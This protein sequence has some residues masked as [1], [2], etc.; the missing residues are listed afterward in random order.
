MSTLYDGII[1]DDN[2]GPVNCRVL[3]ITITSLMPRELTHEQ[4][5][6]W[7]HGWEALGVHLPLRPEGFPYQGAEQHMRTT[8][9]TNTDTQCE[10]TGSYP[11]P[12]FKRVKQELPH[13][14]TTH[15]GIV[16]V[17]SSSLL[18]VQEHLLNKG[19]R[20]HSPAGTLNVPE[21][22]G[23]QRKTG[24]NRTYVM[25]GRFFTKSWQAPTIVIQIWFFPNLSSHVYYIVASGHIQPNLY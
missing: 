14:V 23:Q 24:S 13:K 18:A 12:C 4:M 15:E 8:L 19:G 17:S 21:F 5:D 16:H 9:P 2:Y 22:R 7:M 6:A 1:G 11:K 10:H 3:P 25:R 20:G